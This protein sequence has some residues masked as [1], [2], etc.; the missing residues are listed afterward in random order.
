MA[1]QVSNEVSEALRAVKSQLE[2]LA[3]K[4]MRNEKSI[5]PTVLNEWKHTMVDCAKETTLLYKE[6]DFLLR[7]F[8]LMKANGENYNIERIKLNVANQLERVEVDSNVH[9][10]VNEWF[11]KFVL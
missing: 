10:Q 4:T 1:A 3:A 6:N 5:D 8:D 9:V 7:E 11:L 2:T